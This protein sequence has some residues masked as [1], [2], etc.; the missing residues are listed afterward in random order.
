MRTQAAF[1]RCY[2]HAVPDRNGEFRYALATDM[3]FLIGTGNS[4][5]PWATDRPFMT[6]TGDPDM[7]WATDRPFLTGTGGSRYALG[8][9]PERGI[10][11]CLGYRQAVT[12][13]NGES[14]Y[15]LA[16][17]RPFLTGTGIGCEIILAICRRRPVLRTV[18]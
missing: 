4:D 18:V 14:G 7:P 15:A 13:R 9:R 1:I 2:R 3:P 17:D 8:Y 6:G 5:F 12:D 16:T 10:Q 11:I